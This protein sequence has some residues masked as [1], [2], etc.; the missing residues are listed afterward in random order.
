[1]GG[2]VGGEGCWVDVGERVDGR[3]GGR[4]GEREGWGEDGCVR[5]RGWRRRG[6]WVDGWVGLRE[7]VDVWW[8]GRWMGGCGWV[9]EAVSFVCIYVLYAF[10]IVSHVQCTRKVH[11]PF[12]LRA[13]FNT[14]SSF[15]GTPEE[16]LGNPSS[17]GNSDCQIH[18]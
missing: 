16:R 5:G 10:T 6:V 17:L 12:S 13:S 18:A 4:M 1:M 9:F 11:P 2:C 7:R 8:G 14:C 15:Q 3:G